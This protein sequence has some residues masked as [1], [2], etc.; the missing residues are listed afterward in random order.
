MYIQRRAE[1]SQ[2]TRAF[3]RR[4]TASLRGA[5]EVGLLL[6]SVDSFG[7]VDVVARC[8]APV[9]FQKAAIEVI[10]SMTEAPSCEYKL[11]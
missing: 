3:G 9:E 7:V 4:R 10:A 2:V 1:Q 8:C 11:G 5:L 6:L